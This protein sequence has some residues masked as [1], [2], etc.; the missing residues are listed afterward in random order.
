VRILGHV[1]WILRSY[2][3]DLCD[4]GIQAFKHDDAAWESNFHREPCLAVSILKIFG[5]F[6]SDSQKSLLMG[7]I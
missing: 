7:V 4:H 3:H 2:L 1:G 5:L 6:S